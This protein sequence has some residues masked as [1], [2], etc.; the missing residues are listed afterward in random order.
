V[1]VETVLFAFSIKRKKY[2]W[3]FGLWK[4]WEK[5]VNVLIVNSLGT[6]K[7]WKSCG[8]IKH[9]SSSIYT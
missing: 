1:I 6:P 7:L 4:M 5:L 2:S 8:K 3:M 9:F